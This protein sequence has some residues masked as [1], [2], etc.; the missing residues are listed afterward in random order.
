MFCGH[1]INHVEMNKLWRS[2]QNLTAADSLN[3]MVCIIYLLDI[4]LKL[5]YLSGNCYVYIYQNSWN[6]KTIYTDYECMYTYGAT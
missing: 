5:S 6:I 2:N 4:L 3:R 1:G